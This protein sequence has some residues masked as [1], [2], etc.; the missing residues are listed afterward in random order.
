M[1]R[2]AARHRS[3]GRRDHALADPYS[4]KV[5]AEPGFVLSFSL[6]VSF[7]EQD[8][9]LEDAITAEEL[10]KMYRNQ[11]ELYQVVTPSPGYACRHRPKPP[12]CTQ[13]PLYRRDNY[14]I[15]QRPRKRHAGSLAFA[16]CWLSCPV[17]EVIKVWNSM[18]R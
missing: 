15:E 4:G 13:A 2:A 14:A 5:G 18:R 8:K 11:G 6:Q 12:Y 16:S 17:W 1:S 3:A 7:Q 9:Q 10:V